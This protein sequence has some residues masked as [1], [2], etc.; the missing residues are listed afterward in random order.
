MPV[1]MPDDTLRKHSDRYDDRRQSERGRSGVG[2]G[3]AVHAR[4]FPQSSR[5]NSDKLGVADCDMMD[6]YVEIIN[7][8]DRLHRISFQMVWKSLHCIGATDLTAAQA[9]ILLVIGEDRRSAHSIKNQTGYPGKQ[10]TETIQTLI[11]HGY[12][13]QACSPYDRR[14]SD[15]WLSEKGCLLYDRFAEKVF[16]TMPAVLECADE[17]LVRS[18]QQIEDLWID[19]TLDTP[20]L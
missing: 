7:L 15:V 13:L 14:Q 6:R 8:I 11:H 12:V 5:G 10:F 2:Y 3:A 20:T 4:G 18:L 9:L 17:R 16:D 19:Q 1:P